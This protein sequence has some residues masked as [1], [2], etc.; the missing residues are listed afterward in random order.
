[1]R[2][3]K[4]LLTAASVL[5]LA[6]FSTHPALAQTIDPGSVTGPTQIDGSDI[7]QL[8]DI[9]IRIISA[10]LAVAGVFAVI[11]IVIGGIR[12]I[13]SM[14]DPKAMQS[15][16]GTVTFAIIGLII[17]LLSVAIVLIIGNFLGVSLLNVISIHI[18]T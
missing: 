11:L 5:A 10:L 4:S 16:R 6:L 13:L 17:I 14:G 2:P 1:M 8:V 12:M 9:F 3:T 18:G 15:A 7:H